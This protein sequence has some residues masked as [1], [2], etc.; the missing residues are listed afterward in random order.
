MNEH[1]NVEQAMQRGMQMARNVDPELMHWAATIGGGWMIF[2][3]L[4]RGRF[5]GGMLATIG[6]GLLCHGL[7][8]LCEASRGSTDFSRL[9]R[10]SAHRPGRG[11][12]ERPDESI[13]GNAVDEAGWESFP[14]SDP[15]SYN[16]AIS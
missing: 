7:S 11:G 4:T 13:A 8:H 6:G 16:P 5:L 10:A 15:P 1:S 14:S 9:E 3:G 2:Q 12:P